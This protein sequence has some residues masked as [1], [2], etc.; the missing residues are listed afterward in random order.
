MSFSRQNIIHAQNH[1]DWLKA[2]SFLLN[3]EE[4]YN[5]DQMRNAKVWKK[6]GL[7][8]LEEKR[9]LHDTGYRQI[10]DLENRMNKTAT[11]LKNFEANKAQKQHSAGEDLLDKYNQVQEL[12]KRAI[13][14]LYWVQVELS[15]LKQTLSW[16][17]KARKTK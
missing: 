14:D 11:A 1:L 5:I 17:D 9:M 13:D 6:K 3:V 7:E 2:N 4:I 15:G 10:K 8:Y 16:N 12:Y